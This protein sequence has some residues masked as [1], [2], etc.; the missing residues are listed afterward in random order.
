MWQWQFVRAQEIA[1]E[2]Q[3]EAAEWRRARAVERTQPTTRSRLL[4]RPRIR[5]AAPTT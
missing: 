5:E 4:V 3:A 2:R 1:R